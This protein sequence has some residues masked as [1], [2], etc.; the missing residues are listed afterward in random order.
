MRSRIPLTKPLKSKHSAGLLDIM[1][2][3]WAN[4]CPDNVIGRGR[5]METAIDR[6]GI[7]QEYET[8][9]VTCFY[10]NV[11]ATQ[12]E[13]IENSHSEDPKP[14]S[15]MWTLPFGQLFDIIGMTTI[16]SGELAS[17]IM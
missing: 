8:V 5:L 4:T 12:R 14:T 13:V 6:I 15:L 7:L 9:T 1:F 11:N 17:R 16:V 10:C 3:R 2:A